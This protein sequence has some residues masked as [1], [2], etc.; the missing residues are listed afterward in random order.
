LETQGGKS[1][2]TA[3]KSENSA[4][5]LVEAKPY[6]NPLIF[7]VPSLCDLAATTCQNI[8]LI[9]TN[10]SVFQMLRGTVVVINGIFSVIFLKNKLYPH[11]WVGMLLIA[12]GIGIVGA[13]SVFFS[14]KTMAARNPLLGNVFV[15]GAQVL[16]ASQYVVEEKFVSK[17]NAAPLQVVGWEG[18]MGTCLTMI[19]LFALYWIPGHDNGSLEN[20]P[21]AF[22][23][24]LNNPVLLVTTVI[25]VAS[26]A[27]FNFFGMSIT[28]HLSSTARSTIDASRT[29]IVW[30]IS[31]LMG[32]E[33]FNWIQ[34]M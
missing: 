12:T 6:I 30:A 16:A 9:F 22:A 4:P 34:S 31:L 13:S 32:W 28:K 19:I 23:Q 3:T 8:G 2:G 1:Y 25:S 17:Y 14:G 10:V 20:A 27:F 7:L 11:H 33:K 26:I 5:A 24:N 18:F 29:V 15:V 21:Y